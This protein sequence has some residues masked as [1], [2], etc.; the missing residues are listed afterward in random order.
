M[1]RRRHD[2]R[3]VGIHGAG[4]H[5]RKTT[6]P[7][8]AVSGKTIQLVS[9]DVAVSIRPVPRPAV[10]ALR[11][12]AAVTARFQAWLGAFQERAKQ[13]GISERTLNR[14]F[15]DMIFD[16]DI[17]KKT[18][19]RLNFRNRSGSIWIPPSRTC[20]FPMVVPRCNDIGR[21]CSKSRRNMALKRK[22]SRQ[23]GGWKHHSALIVAATGR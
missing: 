10:E 3:I 16:E 12:S 20:A 2:R 6:W 7:D 21:C 5:I 14:V 19:I 8:S 18:A 4:G 9:A 23:S 15:S 1:R 11:V 13:Q 22:W 17:L